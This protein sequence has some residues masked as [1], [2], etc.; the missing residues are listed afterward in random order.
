MDKIKIIATADLHGHLPEIPKCDL[1]LIGGDICPTANHDRRYQANWLS[2]HFAL[3]MESLPAKRIV[4]TGG[5]HDFVLQDINPAKRSRFGGT[6]LHNISCEIDGIKIWASPFSPSFGN[7]AFMRND[8]SLV[9]IWDDIPYDVDILMVHGPFYGS[10]DKV[11]NNWHSGD[12]CVGSKSLRN[13][14]TYRDFPNLKLFLTG[15]I[16]EGYGKEEVQLG[17]NKFISANVS[18]VDEDYKPGNPPM[19]FEL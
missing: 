16:H 6:Y 9:E 2:G 10:G 14:L 1:L 15:H 8:S 12:T 11:V 13:H 18:Y 7:W 17:N 19:E 4:W 3:W 5:N